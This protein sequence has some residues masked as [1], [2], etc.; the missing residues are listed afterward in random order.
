M[1]ILSNSYKLGFG[2]ASLTSLNNRKLSLSLL[3]HTYNEGIT[4]FDVARLYGMGNAE[5]IVGEFSKGKIEKGFD[6]DLVIFNADFEV[7][8][9][10][11][12]GDFLTKTT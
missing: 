3:E 4:H 1:E 9:T 10:I 11:L 7:E 2:C 12:Q 5:N 6:A 8:G